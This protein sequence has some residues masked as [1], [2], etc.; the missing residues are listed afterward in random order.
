MVI[1]ALNWTQLM[2]SHYEELL[3]AIKFDS[4]SLRQCG[5]NHLNSGYQYFWWL[6]IFVISSLT[7]NHTIIVLGNW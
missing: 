6:E 4:P 5:V 7:T 2:H 1:V 3:I